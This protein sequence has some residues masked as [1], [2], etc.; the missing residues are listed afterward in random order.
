M[1][2]LWQS[3]ADFLHSANLIP[4][5]ILVSSYHYYRALRSHDPVLV[6]VPIALFLDLLHFRT[7]RRAVRSGERAWR[8][9]A[10]F[11]TLLAFGLQWIFYHQPGA[12]EPLAP[13]QA[14]LFASIVPVGLVIMA[15]HHEETARA[16]VV[17]W[18]GQIAA[19]QEEAKTAQEEAA[20]AREDAAAAQKDAETAR[21]EAT[22]AQAEAKQVQAKLAAAQ[23]DATEAQAKLAAAQEEATTAQARAAEMEGRATAAQ[24]D[25]AR[26]G[27]ALA[28]AQRDAEEGRAELTAVQ[29][30]LAA[31]RQDAQRLATVQGAWAGLSDEVQTLARY[32]ARL[33]TAKEAA[34]QLDVHVSTVRRKAK[35]LNGAAKGGG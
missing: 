26:V 11:T 28:A 4:L 27:A 15:W 32:N 30:E 12:G 6:A 14:F 1:R 19:A 25:V 20:A 21:R 3:L 23:R 16:Q 7:V 22:T 10:V 33:L 29:A 18:K 35:K 24:A 8:I 2:F 5:V 31:A 9:A 13:W 34:A 17:D